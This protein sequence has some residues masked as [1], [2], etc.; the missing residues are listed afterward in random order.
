[1]PDVSPEITEGDAVSIKGRGI[2]VIL[3]SKV[4]DEEAGRTTI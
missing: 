2:E 4:V 3:F 1:M